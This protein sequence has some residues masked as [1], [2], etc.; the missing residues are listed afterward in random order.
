MNGHLCVPSED[1][2]RLRRL[3]LAMKSYQCRFL[4]FLCHDRT[5]TPQFDRLKAKILPLPLPFE[6]ADDNIDALFAYAVLAGEQ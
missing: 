3:M 1:P 6:F 5:R 2:F 4:P